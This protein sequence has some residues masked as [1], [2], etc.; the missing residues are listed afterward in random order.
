MHHYTT[1][2]F[3]G[4]VNH[5]EFCNSIQGALNQVTSGGIFLGDNLFTFSRN[6][7]FLDDE[8]FMRAFEAQAETEVEKSALWRYNVL[9]WAARRAMP[10]EGDMVECACYKGVSA[11]I[12]ADYVGLNDSGKKFYL[13]DLFEHEDGM[14]HHDMPEHGADLYKKVKARFKD[15][16]NA[17]VTKGAVP[18]ILNEVAPEKIGFL[19]LDLNNLEAELAALEF[20]WDRITPGASIVFDDYGWLGYRRQQVAE[21]AWL[22]ERGYRPLELPTGQGLLIK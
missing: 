22:E 20:F 17:I 5:G 13:Y 16:P 1:A 15:C 10:I 18:D 21:C 4:V 2:V 12:V 9:C 7:S 11:R 6:L 14:A 3:H 19:H 8:R